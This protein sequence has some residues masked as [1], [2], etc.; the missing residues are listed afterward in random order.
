MGNPMAM[1]GGGKK[2][3]MQNLLGG[4]GGSGGSTIV[5]YLRTL[6]LRDLTVADDIAPHSNVYHDGTGK[7][8]LGVLRKTISADLTIRI[9]KAPGDGSAGAEL[10]TVTLPSTAVVDETFEWSLASG[11]PA[12]LPPFVDREVLSA[13]IL[14]SDGSSDVNGVAEFTVQ[15]EA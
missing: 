15:W 4:G 8:L 2:G 12:V 5:T 6:T 3:M 7:R 13:D 9:L 10:V 1:M 14:A 11:S